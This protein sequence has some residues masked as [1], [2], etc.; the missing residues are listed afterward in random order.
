MT[1]RDSLDIMTKLISA[2]PESFDHT[3]RHNSVGRVAGSYP[4]CHLF[5]SDC[6]YQARWSS[7]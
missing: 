7:G 3:W 4:V 5:E 6:R 1:N 2:V